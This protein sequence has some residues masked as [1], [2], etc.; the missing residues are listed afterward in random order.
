[1]KIYLVTN[2]IYSDYH[3]VAAFSTR[4]LAEAFKTEQKKVEDDG[5]KILEM[6]LDTEAAAVARPYWEVQIDF[7]T[8]MIQDANSG[9]CF[10]SETDKTCVPPHVQ[11][12]MKEAAVPKEFDVYVP[13]IR[14]QSF[15]SQD[16]A[17]KAAGELRQ[18]FLATIGGVDKLYRPGLTLGNYLYIKAAR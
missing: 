2:G 1:M 15:E 4:E 6:E 3:I 9:F 17:R 16:H 14:V 18:T 7:Q 13:T 10:G 8:G 5:V 11:E 12:F